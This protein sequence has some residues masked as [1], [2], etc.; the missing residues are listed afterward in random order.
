[1]EEQ[2]EIVRILDKIIEKE[3]EA[4]TLAEII[5]DKIDEVK[6]S[7]LAKAFRGKLGTNDSS[8]E[9][10]VELLKRILTKV[11]VEEKKKLTARKTKVKVVMKKDMLEAVR[12]ARKITP[13]RLKEETGLGIG[14]FYEE[15]KRLT[16]F[17]QVVEKK[18]GGDVYLEVRDAN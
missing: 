8:D 14:E 13:E 1:L 12:E 5:D 9:P 4:R 15:L 17:G 18:E 3:K 7:I 2:K 11:P 10:A 6:K 16:E